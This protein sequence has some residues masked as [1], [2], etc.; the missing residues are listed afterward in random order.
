MRLVVV[1]FLREQFAAV[2]HDEQPGS[3]ENKQQ[4]DPADGDD[5]GEVG[6]FGVFA[7]RMGCGWI[8]H[9]PW[10]AGL[11]VLRCAGTRRIGLVR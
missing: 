2:M 10:D 3:N 8:R 4:D 11:P 7:G 6:V 1:L 5:K 9:I